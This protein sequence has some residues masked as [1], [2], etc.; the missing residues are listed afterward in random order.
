[1]DDESP[2]TVGRGFSARLDMTRQLKISLGQHSDKGRKETNQDFHGACIP[3]EPQLRQKG[4]SIALAD[5]ISTSSVSQAASQATVKSLLEDYYGT[6][7]AWSVRKSVQQVLMAINSWLWAQTRQSQFRY[8]LERGYVCTLSAL[9]LKSNTAYLFHVGDARI[10]RLRGTALEQLTQDHRVW[11]SQEHSHLS[12]A[13]GMSAEIDIDYQALTLAA[14]DVF[15]CATDGVH[16]FV[17]AKFIA[18]TIAAHAAD[19]DA[20]ARVLVAEAYERGSIDNLTAQIVRIEELPD[21]DADEI[22]R[23]LSGLPFPPLLVP[24]ELFDGYRILRE[25]HASARSHVYLASEDETRPPVVLKTL[26]TELKEDPAQVDRFLMEDWIARRISNAHVM[27]PGDST[28]VRN[29]V[30]TVSEYIDGQTLAQWMIDN[31]KADLETVRGIVEQIA[32]GVSAFHRLEMLHQDLRPANVMIDRRGTVKIIDFGS[33]RVAGLVETSAAAEQT[34]LLGTAQYTAP[35]YFL[36]E[37]GTPRSDQFSL[38]VIAYQMLSGRLPYGAEVARSRTRAAQRRLVYASVLDDERE[39]PA[40]F[41]EVLRKATQPDP[42][43]RYEELSEFVHDLRHP[44]QAWLTRTRPPLLDRNPV[45]F[46]KGLSLILAIVIVIL[47][48]V[49]GGTSGKRGHSELP[50][51]GDRPH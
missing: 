27:R 46:W 22:L 2:A 39:I 9:V 50:G 44:S 23:E 3:Q 40:W 51:N 12:R 36:G 18:Q 8:E 21:Q 25:L 45:A 48:S 26:S 49:S 14:G 19:L 6:S 24:R 28:R 7:H 29:F 20:A 42:A 4:I 34:Q 35:E 47:L 33:T 38:G 31:P 43:K 15:F 41:D 30:Y 1:M 16:E 11:V 37:P 32:Q 10:Y 13:F 17:S 5:G